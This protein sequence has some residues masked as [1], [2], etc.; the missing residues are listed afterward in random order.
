MLDRAG[1]ELNN[2]QVEVGLVLAALACTG[3]LAVAVAVVRARRLPDQVLARLVALEESALADRQTLEALIERAEDAFDRA[4]RKRRSAAAAASRA[5]GAKPE[6]Q[7]QTR[8]E[9]KR[10][11]REQTGVW[12]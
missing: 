6:E 11:V 4:E 5:N 7:P 3:V 2:V 1:S 8:E 10:R 12:T 9:I